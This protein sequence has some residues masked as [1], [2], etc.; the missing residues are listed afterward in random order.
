[1]GDV[2]VASSEGL[3][4]EFAFST[5]SEDQFNGFYIQH[6]FKIRPL[7]C[8]DD[9]VYDNSTLEDYCVD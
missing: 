8:D 3:N 9:E 4:L 6:D 5:G 2:I 1:M 7:Y